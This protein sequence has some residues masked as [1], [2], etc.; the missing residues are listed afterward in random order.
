MIVITGYGDVQLAVRALRAGVMDFI[1][2]PFNNQDLLDRIHQALHLDKKNRHA[3]QQRY[4]HQAMLAALTQR[5]R[6]VLDLMLDGASNKQI[7][8]KLQISRKTL[9]IHRYRILKKMQAA[10]IAELAKKV[11]IARRL[12]PPDFKFVST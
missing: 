12:I 6:M 9:D 3:E 8:A 1:E 11:L 4:E 5:E 7:A 10:N 2:K